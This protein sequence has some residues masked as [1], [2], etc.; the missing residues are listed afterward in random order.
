MKK[1]IKA[2]H[3]KG[4]EAVLK[5]FQ[6]TFVVLAERIQ[7]LEAQL[8]K[9]SSAG[10]DK[11]APRSLRKRSRRRSGE[12][13]G[14]VGD[15]LEMVKKPD[16]I[17]KYTV[18][19][20][21]H[22]Q[23]SLKRQVF[24]LATIQMEVTEHQ[25]Q[26][27]GC[28]GC[29]KEV[30]QAMQYGIEVKSQM[31]YLNHEQHIPL[32]RTCEVFEKFYGHRPDEGTIYA[33]GAETADLGTSVTEAIKEHLTLFEEVIGKDETGM[34]IDGKLYGLQTTG[35]TFLTYYAYHQKRGK[36]AMDAINSLPAGLCTMICHRTFSMIF[37]MPC[38]TLIT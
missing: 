24:D 29:R 4:K 28:T 8:A 7:K 17:K 26:A 11:P 35:T 36:T 27:K 38:A 14:H 31:T 33:A 30:N 37:S 9:N 16:H 18:E 12:K 23:T 15:K 5:L 22:C 20:G 34:R 3:E 1:E 32:K 21:A 19:E 2:A 25:A 10:V 6:E 13:T